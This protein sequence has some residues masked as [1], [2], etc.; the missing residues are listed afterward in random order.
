M[1]VLVDIFAWMALVYFLI[2]DAVSAAI[3]TRTL[4][5]TGHDLEQVPYGGYDVLHRSPFTPPVSILVPARRPADE[6]VALM[7]DLR[8]LEFGEYEVVVLDDGGVAEVFP[9]LYAEFDLRRVAGPIRRQVTGA[10]VTGVY[11]PPSWPGLRVVRTGSGGRATL[12]NAGL[13]VARYPVVCVLADDAVL[14]KGALLRL[15]KPFMDHP[16]ETV[17]AAGIVGGR[18][19]HVTAS[20]AGRAVWYRP[21]ALSLVT[22][23]CCAFRKDTAIGVDGWGPADDHSHV[24]LIL[25]LHRSMRWSK[26]P[27]RMVFVDDAVASCRPPGRWFSAARPWGGRQADIVRALTVAGPATG[28]PRYGLLGVLWLPLAW[29]VDVAGPFI[30]TAGYAAVIGGAVAGVLE[31]SFLALFLVAAIG[32][33]LALALAAV[34][35]RQPQLEGSRSA[36]GLPALL[37]RA[38]VQE[39]GY[40][41]VAALWRLGSVIGALEECGRGARGGR[42]SARR[43]AGSEPTRL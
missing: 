19:E 27:Y 41:Q 16:D 7:R 14:E 37:G 4:W 6:T 9:A 13:N 31:P 32:C 3:A 20:L 35:L 5:E 42:R 34:T 43:P 2:I 28:A 10:A 18:A 21:D 26:R 23:A 1:T 15:V 30:E 12:L 25:R 40:R 38:A 29:L 22:G 33:R 8:L 17:A 11:S 24:D 36:A 39:V